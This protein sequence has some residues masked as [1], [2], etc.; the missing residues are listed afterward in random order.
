S[1]D[2]A[3]QNNLTSFLKENK[4]KIGC[5]DY[6][7]NDVYVALVF[8]DTWSSTKADKLDTA[9][10]C[11]TN[12]LKRLALRP[13]F[14]EDQTDFS[15]YQHYD[16]S[17]SGLLLQSDA[18]QKAKQE[19]E[20]GNKQ[21]LLERTSYF[22]GAGGALLFTLP[23]VIVWVLVAYY[24]NIITSIGGILISLAAYYGYDK[25]KGREAIGMKVIL[26]LV[27]ILAIVVA[28]IA[29]VYMQLSEYGLSL[30]ESLELIQYDPEVKDVFISDLGISLFFGLIGIGWVIFGLSTEPDYIQPAEKVV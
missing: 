3:A 26:V 14:A 9:L 21:R 29:T 18:Y 5:K 10:E 17:G 20:R 15:R 12:E 19:I 30:A 2:L 23:V 4:K 25:F 22:S 8:L 11:L 1:I 7:V 27:T 24:F 28:N 13:S 6:E 16:H